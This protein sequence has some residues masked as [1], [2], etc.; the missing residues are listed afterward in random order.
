MQGRRLA[1]LGGGI[2]AAGALAWVG[3]AIE[4]T[5]AARLRASEAEL[6]E[7]V[8]ASAPALAALK[9]S[10]FPSFFWFSS[11]LSRARSQKRSFSLTTTPE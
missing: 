9:V 5:A 4:R 2:V 6:V 3:W 10:C 8:E 11:S 7:A 1:V